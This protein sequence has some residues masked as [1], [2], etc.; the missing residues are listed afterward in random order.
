VNSRF[1]KCIT[2]LLVAAT[3]F[4]MHSTGL[5][6][7]VA[8]FE[9]LQEEEGR[10]VFT[11]YVDTTTWSGHAFIEL[12]DTLLGT[13]II[14]GKYP[15]VGTIPVRST[16]GHLVDDE[17]R[18]WT[19][20]VRW[21]ITEEQYMRIWDFINAGPG[22]Y[23]IQVENC[24]RWAMDAAREI[25][26]NIPVRDTDTGRSDHDPKGF[27]ET[28]DRIGHGGVYRGGSVIRNFAGVPA[29]VDPPAGS[30]DLLIE[31]GLNNASGMASFFGLPL[32]TGSLD[33]P[34]LPDLLEEFS[35]ESPVYNDL[36]DTLVY[37]D[38]GDGM[39][40]AF[41]T[42]SP[43]H[44]YLWPGDF[45]V[46]LLLMNNTGIWRYVNTISVPGEP[47]VNIGIIGPDGLLQWGLGMKE[48]AV[49]AATEINSATVAGDNNYYIRLFF[50][51]DYSLPLPNPAAASS[52]VER[53]IV[54]EGCNY[55][56][57]GSRTECAAA[58]IEVAADY[59]V[60]FFINGAADNSLM[61]DT[62]GLDYDRYKYVFR[63]NPF[64]STMLGQ[65][66]TTAL[67]LFLIPTKM[68]P[69]YGQDLDG[70]ETTPNQVRV[71]V[72]TENLTWTIDLHD[73][74]TD[75]GTYPYVL[76]PYVNISYAARIP[77]RTEDFT[78]WLNNVVASEARLLI[79]AFSGISTTFLIGQMRA[80]NISALPVGI[81]VMGQYDAYWTAT[82]GG[83]EYETILNFA[84]TRTPIIPG[85]TD[86]FWDNFLAM[87]AMWPTY[88]AAG[89]YDGIRML[90]EAFEATGSTNKYTLLAHF[91][92]SSYQ[93]QGLTG[94]FKFTSLHDVYSN[95]PG[96]L[97][98]EG[99]TRAFCVQWLNG[100]T[101][102]VSPIDQVYSTKWW[103]PPWMYSLVEDINYDGKVN[104]KDVA[105]AAKAFGS[106]PGHPRWE[107][108]ADVV[109][110]PDNKVDMKDIALIAKSFGSQVSLPIPYP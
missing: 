43:T 28:L 58:M 78:P 46:V 55:I 51:D 13:K 30:V 27:E 7:N 98:T 94:T 99:A 49:L 103:L 48:G 72:L 106:T 34:S 41:N 52:E 85:L 5:T 17:D 79:H 59:G 20:K 100:E 18:Q 2:L 97:W 12:E 62:V 4:K 109:Y 38:F 32:T 88:T 65:T 80:L 77:E 37:W 76:G 56:I 96:P 87:Y 9:S 81:N 53:L 8:D 11:I 3:A 40:G 23:D 35:L 50:G 68:L 39:P 57:G 71:A 70:N 1:F 26:K 92:S 61:S 63:V 108:E 95:E 45:T 14:L 10:Y 110:P 105:M 74:L 60:P 21:E 29:W 90:A 102:V 66:L 25:P 22:N 69:L 83:C 36:N 75:P 64:N 47:S 33:V 89:S 67:S 93:R 19:Y 54:D 15:G 86:V 31:G 101:R 16:P 84:G 24:M 44:M 73:I 107:M 82:L 6:W 91:E 42:I 104:I